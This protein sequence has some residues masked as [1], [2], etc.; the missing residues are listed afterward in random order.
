MLSVMLFLG[1]FVSGFILSL[2]FVPIYAFISYQ[3]MYF[4]NP[5][6]RWWGYMV[7]DISYSFF[8][9]I[10]MFLLFLLNFKKYNDNKLLNAPP[11]RWVY[12]LAFLY[13]LASF[14]AVL[15][16]FH[17]EYLTYYLK[18]I[19]I[20]SVAYKLISNRKELHLVLCGYIFSA[21]YMGF[22]V[23][24]I[25]RNSGNRVEGVGLVDSP[26]ANGLA[27]AIAP[28]LVLCLYYYWVSRNWLIKML[29]AFAGV[30]IANS[31]ILIN[32]RGA[33]L[34][35][36]L[37]VLFMMYHLYTSQ[38]QR[39]FQ[40]LTTVF[41]AIA[42]LSGGLYL[43]DDDFIERIAG[44]SDEAQVQEDQ[45]KESGGTRMI[46][47]QSA[48]EMAK[49]HPLGNGYRGFNYYAPIYIPEETDTGGNR[50]RS[51]HSSWF[52]V[53]TEIG[54]L[55][56]TAFILMIFSCFKCASICREKLKEIGDVDE[57][58]KIIALQASLIAFTVAMT[59]LN[60]FRAEILYWLVMFISAAYN[61]YVIKEPKM[62]KSHET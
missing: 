35:A 4:F 62:S 9:V 46:F 32:S 57:Y 52:E 34:G 50:A 30:F 28:S 56:L 44:I 61:V 14:Y 19:I 55:G 39:K 54:Y 53:L 60:R 48:W 26:D 40:K 8:L 47:W 24:Q 38:F 20:I 22:Y 33:F 5:D 3:S 58:F 25:G 59:F 2:R 36:A 49:D 21:W 29:F 15:P 6:K 17:Q 10:F 45:E 12:S 18:L 27:A 7:P 1:A 41:I 16:I 31:L 11:L 13:T 42:G 23:Y 51:V 37:S 43:A